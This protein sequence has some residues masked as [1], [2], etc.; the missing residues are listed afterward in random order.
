MA[1][2]IDKD[3][4]LID[5]DF[6]PVTT[7]I[8]RDALAQEPT[9]AT[10]GLNGVNQLIRAD[11]VADVSP[12]TFKLGSFVQYARIDLEYMAKNGEVAQPI[13]V[14]V[15]RTTP[16]PTGTHENGNNYLPIEEY[17][18]VFSRPL[19]NDVVQGS[20]FLYSDISLMGLDRGEGTG[21]TRDLGGESAG[22]PTHEQTIYAERR[23]YA[24]SNTLGA[25]E[26]NGEL[27]PNNGILASIFPT[28]SLESVTTW[29]T[30]SAITG[31]SLHCYRIVVFDGQSFPANELVFKNVALGG[32]STL[33]YPPV[34]IT[35]V[36]K[37]PKYTEGEYL[38]RL[39][40]AMNSI[41]EDGP[42][43]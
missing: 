41:P 34:N 30:M 21:I 17:I 38:V 36:C 10:V 11:G 27:E 4:R 1:R 23:R 5:I 39:A 37:D 24:F 31:P 19:N 35:F 9:G 22:Y 20:N 28:P 32:I 43:A 25:T 8:S 13:E 3:T 33:Q 6:G 42:T 40:N 29:G 2:L 16:T 18:F 14:N 26:G 7:N 15:Q 12:T